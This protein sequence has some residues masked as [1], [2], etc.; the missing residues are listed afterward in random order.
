MR[1]GQHEDFHGGRGDESGS[2]MVRGDQDFHLHPKLF[3]QLFDEFVSTFGSPGV[4]HMAIANLEFQGI[5]IL[6]SDHVD[7]GRHTLRMTTQGP[8]ELL[9]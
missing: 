1:V 3:T 4:H 9:K 8:R 6:F 5:E 2:R 7:V